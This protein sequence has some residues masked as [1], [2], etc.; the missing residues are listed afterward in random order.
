MLGIPGILGVRPGI[1]GYREDAGGQPMY[2]EKFRV[3]R[4]AAAS[5][6]LDSTQH[7][8]TLFYKF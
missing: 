6:T 5:R 2:L 1:L 3:S 4:G 7:I 8:L